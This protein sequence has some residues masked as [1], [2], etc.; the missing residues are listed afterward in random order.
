MSCELI[1]DAATLT[2]GYPMLIAG[3]QLAGASIGVSPKRT[4]RQNFW[5]NFL[6]IFFSKRRE[7]SIYGI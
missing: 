5:N 3:P 1:E 2:A 4:R 6:S 7:K